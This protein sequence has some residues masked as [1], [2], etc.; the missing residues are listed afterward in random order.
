M[1]LI[2]K[3]ANGCVCCD[4]M[5]VVKNT[6]RNADVS[7]LGGHCEN[8]LRV[9][10]AQ[11]LIETH[12]GDVIAVFH[13]LAL[14][15]LSCLPMEHCIPKIT[16]KSL[17]LPGGKPRIAMDG[18]QIPLTFR[19]GVAYLKCRPQT[20][21]EVDS[22]PHLI[23]TADFDWDSISYDNVILDLQKFYDQDIDEVP[24]GNF[25]AHGNYLHRMVATHLVQ[26]EPEFFDVHEFLAFDNIIDNIVDSLHPSLVEDIYM[27]VIC[28]RI[29][30]FYA[31][32]SLGLRPILTIKPLPLL[33]NTLGG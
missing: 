13:Q 10:T 23:M 8:Q 15:I 6:E 14:S 27:S 5:C 1:D 7:G 19:N 11:A 33:H 31:L 17:R 20:D 25:D 21:A 3:G 12:E 30:I 29:T 26:P 2:K 32:S 9:V 22:L 24:H 16:D 18:Y 28:P 4:D